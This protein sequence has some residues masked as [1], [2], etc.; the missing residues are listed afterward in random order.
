MTEAKAETP[1]NLMCIRHHFDRL[2]RGFSN[3]KDEHERKHRTSSTTKY[4]TLAQIKKLSK[5]AESVR[6]GRRIMDL[7][8]QR[9]IRLTSKKIWM[10]RITSNIKRAIRANFNK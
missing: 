10:R 3:R 6:R 2:Q 4:V 5:T 1:Y 9:G 7:F 8:I